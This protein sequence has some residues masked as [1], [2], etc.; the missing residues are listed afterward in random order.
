MRISWAFILA[1]LCAATVTV[2]GEAQE[3]RPRGVLFPWEMPGISYDFRAEHREELRQS[4]D[5][6]KNLYLPKPLTLYQ[7]GRDNARFFTSNQKLLSETIAA[8][9]QHNLINLNDATYLQPVICPIQDRIYLIFILG[10]YDS[11]ELLAIVSEQIP[12]SSR[13]PGQKIPAGSIP[14]AAE[15]LWARLRNLQ[16]QALPSRDHHF[17]LGLG[18]LKASPDHQSGGFHCPNL[19]VAEALQSITPL[20]LDIGRNNLVHSRDVISPAQPMLRVNH[21]LSLDWPSQMRAGK[22]W[23]EG[24]FAVG[25]QL[26]D[27]VFGRSIYSRREYQFHWTEDQRLQLDPELIRLIQEE[28]LKLKINDWPMVVKTYGA[29]AY[30]DRGRAWGLE[31]NDRLW[32]TRNG[33]TIKGHV[34][35]FYGPELKL[36]SPRGFPI[37]EGAI[38]FVRTGQ[39]EVRPGDIFQFDPTTFPTPWPPQKTPQPGDLHP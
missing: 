13:I 16:P 7:F 21:M 12:A 25:S 38:V 1:W 39:K 36:H 17:K 14:R 32:L 11:G 24:P 26:S 3:V 19:L 8:D 20:Q 27:A 15:Q 18:L 37:S 10:S 34:V 6:L 35:K 31:I 22:P 33:K 28:Q 30:V 9:R 5:A 2:L 4:W 29:W 23:L